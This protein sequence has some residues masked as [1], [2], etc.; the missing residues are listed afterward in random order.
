MR[1]VLIA[2]VVG[3]ARIAHADGTLLGDD[4][5]NFKP[6]NELAIDGGLVVALPAALPAGQALGVGGGFSYGRGLA[7][8]AR[9]EGLTATEGSEF[10]TV[11]HRELRLRA[12]GAATTTAGR[13]TIGLRLGLGGNLVHETR[14]RNQASRLMSDVFETRAIALLPGADLAFVIELHIAGHWLFELAG[15]PTI[16]VVA[17]NAHFG[18]STEL[19]VAWRP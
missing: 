6:G 8:G 13:A 5:W 3:F 17:S 19:G 12:T 7:W 2:V 9:A 16:D 15:G 11:T 18:W 1:L 4:T 10:W 14:T